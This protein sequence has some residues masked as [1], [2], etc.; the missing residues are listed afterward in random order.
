V[1][2]ADKTGK[3]DFEHGHAQWRGALCQG[4]CAGDGEWGV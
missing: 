4:I 2:G 3:N 1:R